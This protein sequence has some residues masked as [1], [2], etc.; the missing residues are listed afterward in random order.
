MKKTLLALCGA[1]PFTGSLNAQC[2][3]ETLFPLKW[4]APKYSINEYYQNSPVYQ[5]SKDT[6]RGSAF[7]HGQNYFFMSR[8][9]DL[10]FF[11]YQ[12]MGSHPCF[13][14]G[15]VVLN[16]VANDSGL[17]AYNYQVTF[18]ASEKAAYFAVLDS[19]KAM[20]QKK[21]TYNS[22]VK[23]PTKSMSA[24]GQALSGEGVSIYFNNEPVVS[25]NLTY[26]QFVIRA[27]YLGKK[28]EPST[29]STIV[30]Q[31]EDVEFYRLEILYKMSLPKW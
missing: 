8:N 19:M 12:S 9:M 20:M 11:S 15:N 21:F 17:V 4:G 22:T 28:P 7:E 18:P 16:C 25:S 1:L 14:T 5:T 3:F 26:P 10:A 6:I 27:G 31:A 24:N 2:T 23:N 30:N 13:S 29:N